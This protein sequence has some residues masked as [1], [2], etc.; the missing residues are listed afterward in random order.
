[1]DTRTVLVQRLVQML[2][3]RLGEMTTV[4]GFV[5]AF[6]LGDVGVVLLV[7]RFLLGVNLAIGHA[8]LDAVLLIIQALI[9]LIYAWMT[10]HIR[11]PASM[12]FS[13]IDFITILLPQGRLFSG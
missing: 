4:L 6:T 10:G 7:A 3:F 8:F 5:G 13:S 12:L 11:I 1:M 2:V 9:N